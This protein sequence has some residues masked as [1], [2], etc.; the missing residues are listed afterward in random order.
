LHLLTACLSPL[1]FAAT[2]DEPATSPIDNF[3]WVPYELLSPEQKQALRSGCTGMYVD[4]MADRLEQLRSSGELNTDLDQL[5]LVIEADAST[6]TDGEVAILSGDVRVSQGPREIGAEV[7][8]YQ[9]DTDQ[10]SL[11]G[12]VTIRQPGVVLRGSE[13][14][15]NGGNNT[16]E[17][18]DAS[19]VLHRQHLRGGAA[20]VQQTEDKVIILRDGKFTSCEPGSNAWSLE[21]DEISLD[22]ANNQGTGRNVVLRVA[23]IP[24]LYVPY[25]SFP[26]GEERK[27][28]LLFPSLS[29]SE[30]NGVDIAQPYYWNIAPNLDATITPRLLFKRGA[31]LELETRHLSANWL[32]QYNGAYLA[33][34]R[35]GLNPEL[36]DQINAGLISEAEAKPHQGKGRW[37]NHFEQIG[38]TDDAWYTRLDYTNVSDNDYFRDLGASSLSLQNTT[39]LNQ[40]FEAGYMF[41]NWQLSSRLQNYQVLLYDVDDPYQR[42]PQIRMDGYYRWQGFGFELDNEYNHFT[43]ND[44]YWADGRPVITGHRLATDYRIN[45][46]RRASWGFFRPEIGVKSLN[47][48]LDD[49]ALSFDADSS[50]GV[51]AAQGS[52]D[53]G[54][55]FEHNSGRFLQTIEPRMFY[56]YRQ[57]DDHSDLFNITDDGQSVNFDTS[58]R[59]FTYSQLYRDTRFSGGDRLDDTRRLTTGVTSRW[60]D[61]STGEELFSASIGQIHYYDKRRIT[62]DEAISNK[63]TSEIAGE[64]R[65][66][67]GSLG[68]FYTTALYDQESSKFSRGTAGMQYASSANE[69]LVNIAYSYVR[70]G[71]SSAS[72]QGL[73]QVDASFI[74]PINKQWYAMGRYNYDFGQSRELE[75]F[76]GLEYNDCC[77]RAR[78]LARRWLDSNIAA[79]SESNDALYDQGLFLEIQLKGLGSSGAK[80]DSLLEDSIYGYRER[81]QLLQQ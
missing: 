23:D 13:A 34:D 37:M 62:L 39:H 1:S 67:L 42:L 40:S 17:F 65:I 49:E 10:A 71:T 22:A 12:N 55:I 47:Y 77:Y 68:R 30:T 8:T 52:I 41:Q 70:A 21:G 24:I 75:V 81:E 38:G 19:F 76:F 50:L 25:I 48:E 4:P 54:L 78:V 61:N 53:T 64:M 58:D 74:A 35:G 36:E 28:G 57:Y 60:Y 3:D 66:N 18:N 29:V 20:S 6:M 11:E 72:N 44:K 32:S 33:N 63:A 7:M 51:A 79:L 31:M 15:M 2:V 80:V 46:D 9:I 5:P 14:H 56:V 43:H 59:T 16:A 69:T 73:D 27:S 26:V 45:W